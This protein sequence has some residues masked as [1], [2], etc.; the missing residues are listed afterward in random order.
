MK[1]ISVRERWGFAGKTY[2]MSAKTSWTGFCATRG[3]ALPN[4][5]RL[6]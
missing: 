3:I 2:W 1:L 5:Q 6:N 4:K